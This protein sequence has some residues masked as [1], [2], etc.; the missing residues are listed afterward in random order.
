M[1][2]S[3]QGA[4]FGVSATLTT[5]IYTLVNC[6]NAINKEDQESQTIDVTCLASASKKKITGL[7]DNGTISLDLFIEFD[8]SGY[9]LLEAAKL[10]GDETAFEITLPTVGTETT[11]RK[12]QF[13]G[14]VKSLP[15]ALGVDAAISGSA[16]IEING[17]VTEVDPLTVP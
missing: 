4:T 1:A 16:S 3:S 8:D 2:T 7:A 13:N 14:F 5:P 6:V 15:W 11:G 9:K 10:S 17:D 12:F